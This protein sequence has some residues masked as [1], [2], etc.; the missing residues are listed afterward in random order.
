VS[1]FDVAPA[2]LRSVATR[3]ERAGSVPLDPAVAPDAGR[4]T[5]AV[6]DALDGMVEALVQAM[7]RLSTTAGGLAAS[8]EEYDRADTRAAAGLSGFREMP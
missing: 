7:Q 5:G 8:A 1:G 2:E 4:T 3:L 6:A